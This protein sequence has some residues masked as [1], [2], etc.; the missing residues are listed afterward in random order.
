MFMLFPHSIFSQY[1]IDE[2]DRQKLEKLCVIPDSLLNIAILNDAKAKSYINDEIIESGNYDVAEVY[3]IRNITDKQMTLNVYLFTIPSTLC[4][5]DW[6]I[7]IEKNECISIYSSYPKLASAIWN[8]CNIAEKRMNAKFSSLIIKTIYDILSYTSLDIEMK[9]EKFGNSTYYY[10]I[11]NWVH[12]FIKNEYNYRGIIYNTEYNPVKILRMHPIS[13]DLSLRQEIKSWIQIT[14][15][16]DVPYQI[17]KIQQYNHNKALYLLE[18]EQH[19]NKTYDLIFR[20]KNEYTIYQLDDTY[21]PLMYKLRKCL[22]NNKMDLLNAV[23]VISLS[24]MYYYYMEN[25]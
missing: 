25:E 18:T 13:I 16:T 15:K 5:S 7:I 14:Y 3:L 4:H 23:K 12:I 8:L 24:N 6:G 19:C 21:I 9:D 2:F 1:I 20:N 10:T 17:Y 11:S 22:K